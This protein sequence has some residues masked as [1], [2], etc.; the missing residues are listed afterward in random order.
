MKIR[1]PI[2]Q[3]LVYRF[4]SNFNFEVKLFENRSIFS[5][6]KGEVSKHMYHAA[7]LCCQ[8]GQYY[9]CAWNNHPV[10]RGKLPSTE[11]N[12]G[13]LVLHLMFLL[14]A[15]LSES[16]YFWLHGSCLRWRFLLF[17]FPGMMKD[18]GGLFS[19]ILAVV[20]NE[21]GCF[22]GCIKDKTHDLPLKHGK[23][24]IHSVV[25]G[26]ASFYCCMWRRVRACV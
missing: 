17:A 12:W 3:Y 10:F 22:V 16:E 6:N 26:S 24:A 11:R 23:L 7:D 13:R 8:H 1:C 4:A 19:T 18:P 5:S 21:S 14:M 2:L 15:F 9:R 25:G 20:G